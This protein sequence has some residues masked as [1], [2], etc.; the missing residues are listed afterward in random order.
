VD[1][2]M[3]LKLKNKIFYFRAVLVQKGS[4]RVLISYILSHLK[5]KKKRR[6]KKRKRKGSKEY[7]LGNAGWIIILSLG[8]HLFTKLYITFMSC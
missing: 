7:F 3:T 1:P 8:L 2:K 4:N 5:K 6:K